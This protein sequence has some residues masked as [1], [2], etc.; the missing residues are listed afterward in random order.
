MST[1][2]KNIAIFD[3]YLENLASILLDR[4]YT[5]KEEIKADLMSHYA[6]M[7][8]LQETPYNETLMKRKE[9]LLD[10]LKK[11]QQTNSPKIINVNTE[12]SKLKQE[13]KKSN[14]KLYDASELNRLVNLRRFITKKFGNEWLKEWNGL[15]DKHVEL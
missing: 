7:M 8:K 9:E 6:I 4:N 3:D 1:I 10:Y 11:L 15:E 2:N 14:I 5:S 12:L 13:I